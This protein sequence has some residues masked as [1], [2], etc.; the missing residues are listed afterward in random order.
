MSN[1]EKRL[2]NEEEFY[3]DV[4]Y[5]FEEWLDDLG[6]SK[7]FEYFN[8]TMSNFKYYDNILFK[9]NAKAINSLFETPYEALEAQRN[10]DYNIDDKYFSFPDLFS[11]NNIPYDEYIAEML[12]DMVKTRLVMGNI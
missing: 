10:G 9:N 1:F 7:Q 2:D 4:R 5:W 11:Y 6:E 12:D 8:K 3:N